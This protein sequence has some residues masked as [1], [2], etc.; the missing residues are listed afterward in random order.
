MGLK[1]FFNNLLYLSKINLQ[2]QELEDVIAQ[3]QF[4][5]IVIEAVDCI[6]NFK[7]LNIKNMD[8]TINRLVETE[9]SIV[10]FGDG[11]LNLIMGND[12]HFQKS[13]P[14]LQKSLINVLSS[15]NED[16]L[17]AI[18]KS[19]YSNKLNMQ[20]IPKQF[21]RQNGYLYRNV[22]EKYINKNLTYY[23]SEISL[24]Y[25]AYKEIDCEYYFDKLQNIW[26]NKDICI[27]CG[28]SV[29]DKIKFN[30]FE[31]AKSIEYC[32]VPAKNAYEHYGQILDNSKK[33][34]K[35]KMIIGILGPTSCV[36]GLD[37]FLAG[38]RFLDLGHVAKSYDWYS[39]KIF[40]ID[41]DAL[42]KFFDP[43]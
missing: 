43:D 12:I 41:K 10:R 36:L 23:S 19:I 42:M 20:E 8:E 3:K 17:I 11:E 25:T 26:K 31:T 24:F 39:R 27:I 33:I 5:E 2:Q 37:L 35:K 4:D 9:S 40:S 28:D 18:P 30:I 6:K 21:W 22:I 15:Y 38:Y 32:C 13:S 1:K 16:L 29:F 14:E 34:D 7:L